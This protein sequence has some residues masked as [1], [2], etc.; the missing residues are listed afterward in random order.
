MDTQQALATVSDRPKVGDLINEFKRAGSQG[1]HF[2]RMT[3]AEDVRL[4][5]WDGQSEDGKK[6]AEDMPEGKEVF[7]FEGSSD[8]RN[9]Q[10]DGAVN[11]QVALAYMAFWNSVLKISGANAADVTDA[12]VATSYLDWMVHF[13]LLRELDAEVE[14]SAQFIHSVGS[15]GLHVTWQREVGRK[16]V[17]VKLTEL[18][19]M[20][21][22][23]NQAGGQMSEG[24]GQTMAPEQQQLVEVLNYLP[25]LIADKTLEKSA[26]EAIQFI[27]DQYIRA[28]IAQDDELQESDVLLLS[29]TR[30][31]QAVRDLRTDGDCELPIPY[32][33]KNRPSISALKPYRDFV[34]PTEA[35]DVQ[36][37]PIVFV[38]TTMTE[39]EIRALVLSDGWDPDWV[40][41]AVKTRGKFSTWQINNP[42]SQYST[43]SFRAVDNRSWLIE[44]VW[45][46]YKQVD[47]DGVTQ[48]TYTVFSPHLTRNPNGLSNRA[49]RGT[50]DDGR[51][52]ILDDFAA[53]HGILNYPRAEYPVIIGRRE[54]MDR[55][56][57]ASR[58]LPEIL[59]TGQQIEKNMLDNVVDL[60]SISTIPPLLVPKGLAT[61]YTIGPAVQNEYLPGR[62]PKFMQMPVN[63]GGPAVEVMALIERKVARYA[64][65]FHP[66]VMPQLSAILQQPQ[67]KKFLIM[68]GEA[69]QMAYELTLKFAPERI[70]KVTGTRPAGDPDNFHY[71]MH[72]DATQLQPDLM[73][74]KLT[75]LDAVAANDQAGV[76]DQAALT[77]FKMRMID[78]QMAKEL[79]VDK[80]QASKKLFKDVQNDVLNMLAGSEPLYDDASNDPAAQMKS[81]YATQ[82]LTTNPNY[83]NQLDPQVAA[84]V[85]GPQGAQMAQMSQMQGGGK[86]DPRFSALVEN[87]FKNLQQGVNQQQNKQVGRTGVK[88]LT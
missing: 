39:A 57:L 30:A 40:E 72:F 84:K 10:A 76:M 70:E 54:R 3:R 58:G 71:V 21:D 67:I 5:R 65:L 31:K 81:Q 33:C 4:A 63:N 29:D 6:H 13:E 14:M 60:A 35:G 77:Q 59:A 20:R 27:Y 26:I 55:S 69:L 49:T 19:A 52:A 42:Y 87:Y 25:M 68:W 15:A 37:S 79:T 32:L 1:D 22:Q 47:E 51:P 88:N 41:E 11:E 61:K 38:R 82:I 8:C 83:L 12:G 28:Q 36:K 50:D 64:G 16:L 24:G 18:L 56:W 45:G 7:P 9:F 80:G 2:G 75:A 73:A 85:L 34:L 44:V 53:K 86:P 23:L 74:A 78:P 43:W 46:Y 17:R 66:E 48:V 62:E